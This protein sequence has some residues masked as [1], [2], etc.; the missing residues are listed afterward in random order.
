M[1]EVKLVR[2]WWRPCWEQK[3]P[4]CGALALIWA[5]LFGFI[6]Y[7]M[8]SGYGI[9][10]AFCFALILGCFGGIIGYGHGLAMVYSC[11]SVY[12]KRLRKSHASNP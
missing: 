12:S 1:L 2:W 8:E 3:Q 6:G 11:R 10:A 7:C 4:F 9:G 5:V